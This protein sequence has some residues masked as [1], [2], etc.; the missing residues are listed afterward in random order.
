[1]SPG[2]KFSQVA[3]GK[4]PVSTETRHRD[5]ATSF[6]HT[7]R[8]CGLSKEAGCFGDGEA[9]FAGH[10]HYPPGVSSSLAYRTLRRTCFGPSY[11]YSLI[12]SFCSAS[13]S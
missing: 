8:N 5:E 9:E 10:I 1:M 7:Q 6:P 13:R 2:G 12:V 4:P 3:N 11:E